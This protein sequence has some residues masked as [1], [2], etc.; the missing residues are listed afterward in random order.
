MMV[1]CR[2]RNPRAWA[3]FCRIIAGGG[4]FGPLPDAQFRQVLSGILNANMGSCVILDGSG[5]A[6]L[7]LEEINRAALGAA[8]LIAL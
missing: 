5:P 1:H 7:L 4:C 2:F 8:S 3:D 6:R